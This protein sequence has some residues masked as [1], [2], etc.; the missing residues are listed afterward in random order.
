MLLEKEI[1]STQ[2]Q[3]DSGKLFTCVFLQQFV[4]TRLDVECTVMGHKIPALKLFESLQV[5]LTTAVCYIEQD[6]KAATLYTSIQEV[7]G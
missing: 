3:T 2:T 1:Q 7:L 4:N 6:G 5:S